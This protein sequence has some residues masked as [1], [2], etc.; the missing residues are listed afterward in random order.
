MSKLW[1]LK[2]VAV[3]VILFTTVGCTKQVQ[4]TFVNSTS[5]DLELHVEGPGLCNNDLGTIPAG[6]QLRTMIKVSE[7]DLPHTYHYTAGHYKQNFCLTKDSQSRIYI[8]IPYGE[9]CDDPDLR[10][11]DGIKATGTLGVVTYQNE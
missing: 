5:Q 4:T 6:G 8:T 7:F 1:N 3:V 10:H 9:K 2:W 11:A